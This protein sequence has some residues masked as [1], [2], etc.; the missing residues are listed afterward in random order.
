M[1]LVVKRRHRANGP[2]IHHLSVMILITK[3]DQNWKKSCHPSKFCN[4]PIN[5]SQFI[6]F[7]SVPSPLKDYRCSHLA[8]QGQE[9]GNQLLAGNIISI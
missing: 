8:P 1:V 6:K 3:I 2:L 7:I 4:T 9:Q 5:Y